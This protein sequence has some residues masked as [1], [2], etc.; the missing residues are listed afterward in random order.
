M[1]TSLTL[2]LLQDFVYSPV[3]AYVLGLLSFM[4]M[5]KLLFIYRTFSIGPPSSE[6]VN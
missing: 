6:R 1:A 5:T 4:N 3:H 2:D